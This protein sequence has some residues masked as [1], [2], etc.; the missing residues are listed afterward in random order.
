MCSSDIR[1]ENVFFWEENNGNG[2]P[3]LYARLFDW[4]NIYWELDVDETP[5]D[6][7]IDHFVGAS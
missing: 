2:E 1:K 7:E 3:E 5:S 6:A 4:G